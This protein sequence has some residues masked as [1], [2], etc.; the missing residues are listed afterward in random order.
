MIALV[1]TVA[2]FG[3]FVGTA[4]AASA[5]VATFPSAAAPSSSVLFNGTSSIITVGHSAHLALSGAMT[6]EAWVRPSSTLS[7]RRDIIVKTRTRGGFPYGLELTNGVPD[8]YATIGAKTVKVSATSPLTPHAWSFIAAY[9]NGHSLQLYVND[10]LLAARSAHGN[11]ST[12]TGPLQI[13]GDS[14]SGRHYAGMIDYV[15][16]YTHSFSTTQAKNHGRHPRPTTPTTTIH[17]TP[18]P[19]TPTKPTTTPTATTA[20]TS[21]PP[22]TTLSPSTAPAPVLS[23][24]ANL[25]V[26][27]S[28]GSCARQS[29]KGAEV[30]SGDCGTLQAA[31]DA[32]QCGDTINIDSGN[33]GGDPAA[34]VTLFDTNAALRG[35]C[36]SPVVIE[37]GPGATR[38][39]VIFGQVDSGYLGQDPVEGSSN[40]FI[41]D[42]TIAAVMNVQGDSDNDTLNDIQG[43]TMYINGARNFTLE[44]SNM[45][46]CYN[47]LPGPNPAI[48]CQSNFKVDPSD[49]SY[50]GQTTENITLNHDYFHDFIDNN[51]NSA[52][53]HDECI[54]LNG[55]VNETIENSKFSVCQLYAIFLQPYSGVP[56]TNLVIQN[57]WFSGT[58]NGGSNADE[59]GTPRNTAVEL[60]SNGP[61][62]I[63]GA[64]IRFNSFAADEGITQSSFGNS[65]DANDRIIA[66]ILGNGSCDTGV[67]YGYNLMINQP[68]CG[69]GD[70]TITTSPYI[71]PT[72]TPSGVN[73]YHL[74][75]GTD[76]GT[77]VTPN[78]ADYQIS[79]D[80]DGNALSSTGPRTPGS[81]QSTC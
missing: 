54:F 36:S 8:A 15:R 57:N 69:T 45:G 55:G 68:T 58:E 67:T 22:T 63:D 7:G 81:E 30:S 1:T 78:T 62:G 3:G 64:L 48:T 28:G 49:V 6:L 16:V 19:P 34:P 9:Y 72:E 39:S 14:E 73:N 51:T 53:D 26:S 5:P 70:T 56:F 27:L 65:N 79:E 4:L 74:A 41:Q 2:T 80:L 47:T 71:N 29:T 31:W 13:G 12:S 20:T 60:G 75:C 17:T 59:Y 18:T 61:I 38:S 24:S 10:R 76:L 21:K 23:A 66:N 11:L 50:G 43:G 52:T 42:I 40:W 77:F 35:T 44:N 32:A 37:P 33:Y 25:W 46:P